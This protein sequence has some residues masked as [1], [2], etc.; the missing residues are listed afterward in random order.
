MTALQPKEV[1]GILP[2][3]YVSLS[4]EQEE[5]A[6]TKELRGVLREWGALMRHYYLVLGSP[7]GARTRAWTNGGIRRAGTAHARVLSDQRSHESSAGLASHHH[8]SAHP[9]CTGSLS[10]AQSWLCRSISLHDLGAQKA[11]ADLKPRVMSNIE[12]G[13]RLLGLD[14]IVKTASGDP[15]TENNMP[16]MQLYRMVCL[17]H[18]VFALGGVVNNISA[19]SSGHEQGLREE[20]RQDRRT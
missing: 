8:L 9:C 6:I 16:I 7:P 11:L 15:A 1:K 20:A 18:L 3:S 13:R 2:K 14:L 4:R 10:S 12:E 19:Q 17:Y 5:D